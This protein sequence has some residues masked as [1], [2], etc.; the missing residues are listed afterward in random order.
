ME[1]TIQT[2]E[3]CGQE[4]EPITSFGYCVICK[5]CTCAEAKRIRETKEAEWNEIQRAEEM[6]TRLNR[7]VRAG[8]KERYLYAAAD[9]D[10]YVSAVLK[11]EGLYISGDIGVGKTHLAAAITRALIDLGKTVRFLT[12]PEM[13]T[14][15][16]DTYG[17]KRGETAVI[18]EYC[19]CDVL[20][21]DDLG[22]ELPTEWVLSVLFRIVNARYE[23]NLPIIITTN[24]STQHLI[25]RFSQNGPENAQA[26]VS[27]LFE[28]CVGVHMS[29]A[30]KRLEK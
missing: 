6:K 14:K 27:R 22:K 17:S 28:M 26:L 16:K 1:K 7:Y 29:G 4:L 8:L 30:D 12:A 18:N 9:C 2:C 10:N 15:I 13:L 24:Y 19:G 5:P 11:G 21:I 25:E 3:F 20:V 23:R